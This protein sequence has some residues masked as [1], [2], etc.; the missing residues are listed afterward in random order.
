MFIIN[1][2]PNRD[3]KVLLR[4]LKQKLGSVPP[5]WELFAA[6]N[7]VRFK[8][9]L[10]EINYLMEHPRIDRDFFA[11]LRYAVA[12]DNGYAYCEKFDRSL[13]LAK[14]YTIEQ[15]H[16]LEGKSKQIPLDARHQ[17]LFGGVMQAL[18]APKSFDD[19][20]IAK[21][22][23]AGWSDADIFDAIDHGAFLHKFARILKAYLKG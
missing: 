7:P 10:D 8:M 4:A 18:Q 21:L 12:C 5:H 23:E 6:L 9:F 1:P 17:K 15:L 14:G 19:G 16:G 3:T 20:N 2:Q 11:M 22:H 13:L